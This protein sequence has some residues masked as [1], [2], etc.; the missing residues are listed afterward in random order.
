[1]APMIREALEIAQSHSWW[2]ARQTLML[3]SEELNRYLSRLVGC[4]LT[5]SGDEERSARALLVLAATPEY[6]RHL[7]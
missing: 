7:C 1:M 6:Y 2:A 3:P 5:L 4:E